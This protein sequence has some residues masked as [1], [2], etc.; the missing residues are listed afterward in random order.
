MNKTT[1]A[2]IKFRD[3]TIPAIP[4][5]TTLQLAWEKDRPTSFFINWA[6]RKLFLSNNSL[7]KFGV[8]LPGMRSL[9]KWGMDSV[10]KSIG[11]KRVEPDGWDENG[12]P[13]W[14]LAMGLM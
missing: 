14:L 1:I 8:K 5:G 3:V 13:S 6:E 7:P 11:G 10:C 12:T 4:I 9:E 2:E